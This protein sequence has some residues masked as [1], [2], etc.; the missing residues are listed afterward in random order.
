M[1]TNTLLQ[2]FYKSPFLK[3]YFYLSNLGQVWLSETILRAVEA[4]PFHL[5][6][7]FKNS[8]SQQ[9][10]HFSETSYQISKGAQLPGKSGFFFARF[11]K[12]QGPKN[13]KN[14]RLQKNSRAILN[15]KLSVLESTWDF[16]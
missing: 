12:T 11:K 8:P 1:R 10:Q 16:S 13:S 6:T 9:V 14:L 2:S 4:L 5:P 3:K 15:K 7:S